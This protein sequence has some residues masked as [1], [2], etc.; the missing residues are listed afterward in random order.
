MDGDGGGVVKEN[1]GVPRTSEWRVGR[2]EGGNREM[3]KGY[4]SRHSVRISMRGDRAVLD[5]VTYYQYGDVSGDG[6]GI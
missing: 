6:K 4:R 5:G 2:R 1:G 3:V